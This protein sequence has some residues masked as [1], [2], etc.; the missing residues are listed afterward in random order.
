VALLRILVHSVWSLL[1]E[2]LFGM[3]LVVTFYREV[4]VTSERRGLMSFAKQCSIWTS[5]FGVQAREK[6]RGQ[7][8]NR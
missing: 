1:G 8:K 5:R 3:T 6:A 2:V 7:L 4:L